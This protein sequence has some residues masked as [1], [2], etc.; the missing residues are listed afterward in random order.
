MFSLCLP[1]VQSNVAKEFTGVSSGEPSG[2]LD[3]LTLVR[4]VC[5]H[6]ER[7]YDF[8]A[9]RSRA[10][11]DMPIHAQIGI[12]KSG[13]GLYRQGKT[14]LF[15]SIICFKYLLTP[16]DFHNTIENIDTAIM[17]LTIE[18]KMIPPN[19]ILSSMGFPQNWKDIEK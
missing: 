4:N 8:S 18:T 14:D 5:A 13:A 17:K 19:K 3:M 16:E 11:Q 9:N 6:N 7:L 1:K 15:A 12:V 10:I 2:M